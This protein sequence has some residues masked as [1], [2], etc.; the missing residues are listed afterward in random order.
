MTE[1]TKMGFRLF[2]TKFWPPN[3]GQILACTPNLGSPGLPGLGG[4]GQL[5]G[6]DEIC[7]PFQ[8]PQMGTH[9]KVFNKTCSLMVCDVPLMQ[10]CVMMVCDHDVPL[11]NPVQV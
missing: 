2:R 6:F 3:I 11:I 8:W 1:N 5:N 10:G 4:G 7:R 9:G